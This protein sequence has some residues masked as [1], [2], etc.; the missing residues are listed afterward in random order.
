MPGGRPFSIDG[1]FAS[2]LFPHLSHRAAF[3]RL[4][5]AG[6][7]NR[8]YELSHEKRAIILGVSSDQLVRP[9][10]DIPPKSFP[11]HSC[12]PSRPRQPQPFVLR[13]HSLHPQLQIQPQRRQ[14]RKPST[15]LFY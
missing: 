13:T 12:Q 7:M 9:T 11:A 5:R 6:G 3:N 14:K 8:L 2:Q 1:I 15:T 10:I 4:R